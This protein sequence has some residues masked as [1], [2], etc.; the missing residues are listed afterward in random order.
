MRKSLPLP[1]LILVM[2]FSYA[3]EAE[4]P[5]QLVE[6]PEMMQTH[7]L[8]HMRDHLSAL[9]EIMAYLSADDPDAA[10]DTAE[11]RLGVSSMQG[12]MQG[13]SMQ[14]GGGGYMMGRHMPEGMR[15]IGQNVHRSASR[16]ALTAQERDLSA[17]Y[18]AL[19]PVTASCVACHASY[20][21]R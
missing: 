12:G 2:P 19:L 5:R 21:V 3:V 14:G 11:Q 8:E 6:L 13:G 1:A 15:A 10:A 9:H 4:D 18:K 20:R 16:F 17:A 7:M